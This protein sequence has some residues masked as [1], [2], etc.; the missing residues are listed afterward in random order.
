MITAKTIDADFV[1]EQEYN[2]LQKAKHN[3]EYLE[4]LDRSL[5]Q[6]EHGDVVVKS[7][8]ELERM[9]DELGD[10]SY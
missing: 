10:Y 1:S 3:E 2:E 8:D 4:K 9:S 5:C 6:L 7:M